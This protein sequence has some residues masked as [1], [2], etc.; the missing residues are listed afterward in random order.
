[1]ALPVIRTEEDLRIVNK[2]IKLSPEENS[3]LDR[4]RAELDNVFGTPEKVKT[5]EYDYAAAVRFIEQHLDTFDSTAWQ[6]NMHRRVAYLYDNCASHG[7]NGKPTND[8]TTLLNGAQAFQRMHETIGFYTPEAFAQFDLLGAAAAILSA[9]ETNHAF[10]GYLMF[11]KAQSLV[12]V[13][14]YDDTQKTIAQAI[15]LLD[16]QYPDFA[17]TMDPETRCCKT[18]DM[19]TLPDDP[20]VLMNRGS[21]LLG[22]AVALAEKANEV[23]GPAKELFTHLTGHEG[24]VYVMG[25]GDVSRALTN[26]G[27]THNTGA[28]NVTEITIPDGRDN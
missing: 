3:E 22:K 25:K 21:A 16:K 6:Y 24:T 4:I 11:Q 2:R 9:K 12:E 7:N 13:V 17:L 5:G 19:S 1:M 10:M 26:M 8:V 27:S 20:E 28:L 15:T 14:D 23:I 18:Y